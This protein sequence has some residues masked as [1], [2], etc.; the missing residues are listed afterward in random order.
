MSVLVREPTSTY[1]V[2]LPNGERRMRELVLYIADKC[3]ADPTFGATKLNKILFWAD[4]LSFAVKGRPVTGEEYQ[5]LERGPAPRGMVPVRRDMKERGE[6]VMKVVQ[7]H[8]LDQHRVV[9]L[10]EPD[11]T[12]FDGQDI[13]IV[14]AVIQ[15]LWGKTAGEVSHISHGPWWKVCEDGES[16]PYEFAYL[17]NAP[18][19]ASD[20][21]RTKELASELGWQIN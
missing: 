20:I 17:S 19:N 10:R 6:I 9:A 1:R 16:I 13:A 3:Q 7:Y 21:R 4:F 14:D 18:I 11:L 15:E 8:G 12:I 2:R 5:R